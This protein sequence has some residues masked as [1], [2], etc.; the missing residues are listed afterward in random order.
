MV[1][2][3]IA[4]QRRSS[5]EVRISVPNRVSYAAPG[6][7]PLPEAALGSDLLPG[8]PEIELAAVAAA[9][10]PTAGDHCC[11]SRCHSL[12]SWRVGGKGRR[13]H[14]LGE[15]LSI[16]RAWSRKGCAPA[17]VGRDVPGL[18]GLDH[19]NVPQGLPRDVC[20]VRRVLKSPLRHDKAGQERLQLTQVLHNRAAQIVA[21]RLGTLWAVRR[22]RYLVTSVTH[23][24]ASSAGCTTAQLERVATSPGRDRRSCPEDFH[25]KPIHH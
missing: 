11:T 23:Q 9:T 25:M 6:T 13:E 7:Q 14:H 2:V 4:D 1:I 18:A 19:T 17:G 3:W 22:E 15:V 16:E 12:R 21:R 8:L 5:V 20:S 10:S 24:E